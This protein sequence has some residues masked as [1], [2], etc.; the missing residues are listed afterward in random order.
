MKSCHFKETD[1]L[2]H[3]IF[4]KYRIVQTG[5]RHY[6]KVYHSSLLNFSSDIFFK[7]WYRICQHLERDTNIIL[8]DI[9]SKDRALIIEDL[10]QICGE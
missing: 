10:N 2:D 5:S 3:P 7:Y 6:T 1:K 4:G 8:K 9:G